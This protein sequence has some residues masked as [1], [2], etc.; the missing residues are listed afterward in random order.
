MAIYWIPFSAQLRCNLLQEAYLDSTSSSLALSCSLS[1]LPLYLVH[2][3]ANSLSHW[4]K[5][6]V[7]FLNIPPLDCK[8]TETT[9]SIDFLFPGDS[10]HIFLEESPFP[11]CWYTIQWSDWFF[12][13]PPSI[14]FFSS[15]L[16]FHIL[17][18]KVLFMWNRPFQNQWNSI[19]GLLSLVQTDVI[20]FCWTGN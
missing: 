4:I 1:V 6:S 14:W 15:F 8:L 11:L 20:S 19:I 17:I 13:F 2:I 10:A 7:I 16:E 5:N 18:N 12:L 3:F 9:V